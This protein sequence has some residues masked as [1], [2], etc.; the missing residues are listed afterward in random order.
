MMKIPSAREFLILLRR[1]TVSAEWSPPKAMFALKFSKISFC[2]IWAE[3]DSAS[4][5]PWLKLP[6]MLLFK[7]VI[8]APSKALMPASRLEDIG[9]F[10]MRVKL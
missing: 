4:K 2:S 1:I 9:F 8:W 10:S 6:E 5:M 7:I 3:L